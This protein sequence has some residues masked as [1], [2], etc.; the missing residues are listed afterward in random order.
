MRTKSVSMRL[1]NSPHYGERMAMHWLDLARYADTHGYH[2]D[3]SREMWHWRDW[4][5]DA[6]TGTC[7][8]IEFTIDQLA[9]DLIPERHHRTEACQRLQPQ[10][11]DQLRRRRDSRGISGGVRRRSRRSHLEH[12][13]GSD[14]GLCACHDHKYDPISQKDFYQFFAFFNNVSEKG[15]DGRTGN[16]SLTCSC[17]R[18][19]RKRSRSELKAAIDAHEKALPE[20]T[21]A[22]TA[23]VVGADR[24]AK[25]PTLR[26]RV[27][28]LITNSTEPVDSSGPLSYGRVVHG[29]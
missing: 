10:S 19:N 6:S 17:L 21:L 12:L 9:G 15:L 27:C 26:A 24:T 13:D 11:H 1:L 7:P 4:V 16:A 22:Q 23:V 14:D 25:P 3:S 18:R 8:S 29:D 5:I 20:E 2:I 28:W